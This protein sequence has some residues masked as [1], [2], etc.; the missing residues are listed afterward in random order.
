MTFTMPSATN[1]G[2]VDVIVQGPL[3]YGK[4]TQ[5]VRY[6]NLNPYPPQ[7]LEWSNHVPY[8]MKYLQ[9]IEII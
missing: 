8:Q 3:G 2:R 4:L 7:S 5:G 9:G 6:S 1:S